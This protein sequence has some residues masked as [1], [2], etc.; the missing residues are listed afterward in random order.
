MFFLTYWFQRERYD[1]LQSVAIVGHAFS[2]MVMSVVGNA[3]ICGLVMM[4][5]VLVEMKDCLGDL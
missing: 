2:S 5:R 1:A 3:K 4:V